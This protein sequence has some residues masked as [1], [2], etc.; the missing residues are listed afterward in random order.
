M[1]ATLRPFG[2]FFSLA[3]AFSLRK[4]HEAAPNWSECTCGRN[5]YCSFLS[6]NTLEATHTLAHMNLLAAS[7]LCA[8]GT[9]C[10]LE[11]T[12]MMR[13]TRSCSSSRVASLIAT[14]AFDCASA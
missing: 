5:T 12:P 8:I 11:N 4:E 14:S 7:T 2:S 13:S 9:Q 3:L 1:I 10:A 6:L